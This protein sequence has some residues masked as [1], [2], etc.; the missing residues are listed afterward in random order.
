MQINS[1]ESQPIKKKTHH[2]LKESQKIKQ[3]SEIISCKQFSWLPDNLIES[4]DLWD[5]WQETL[6]KQ[7]E[8]ANLKDKNLAS[9]VFIDFNDTKGRIDFLENFLN[10]NPESL[11]A[12]W[13]MFQICEY[14][15]SS[16]SHCDKDMIENAI[17]NHPDNGALLFQ[18]ASLK[19]QSG[20][21]SGATYAFQR[22]VETNNFD[23]YYG[24]YA[25]FYLTTMLNV[26][27]ENNRQTKMQAFAF[28]S[29]FPIPN[30]SPLL[31]YCRE[32]A[33]SNLDTAQLC[34]DIGKNMVSNSKTYIS[35][36]I[37]FALQSTVYKITENK[38][39][40]AEIEEAKQQSDFQKNKILYGKA[41]RLKDYDDL[42]FDLYY[43]SLILYGERIANVH[44]IEE[45]IRLSKNPDYNPCPE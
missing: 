2:K 1:V 44:L 33:V 41:Q 17:K 40:Q 31:D 10:Q 28:F 35:S 5:D 3:G 6:K 23:I 37:G 15:K 4:Q 43:N 29:S 16:R 27:Y 19:Y 32:Q 13:E 39:A 7:L 34:L 21:I 36:Q 18:V 9:L 14:N 26:G 30:F 42:L 38:E 45:A 12:N 24:H 8:N 25:K 22:L 11:L 20:D